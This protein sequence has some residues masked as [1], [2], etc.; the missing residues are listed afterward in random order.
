MCGWRSRTSDSFREHD[1]DATVPQ[2]S[3]VTRVGSAACP[4]GT[5]STERQRDA[6]RA[7]RQ[8]DHALRRATSRRPVPRPGASSRRVESHGK[9]LEIVWDDGLILHTHMR[10]TG[11][12]HLYRSGEPWRRPVRQLRVA[13]RGRRLGRGVLQRAGRRDLPRSSTGAPPGR[14]FARARPVQDGRRPRRCIDRLYHYPD[15]VDAVG[16]VLLDQHV[17]CGVGNV[18]RCEVLWATELSPWAHVGDLTHHDA[19]VLVNTAATMLRR[20]RARS[21]DHEHD[22]RGGLAVYGR[23]GQGCARCHE[24]IA[25]RRVGEHARLLYWCEGCQV[26]LDPRLVDDSPRDGSSPGCG[27]VPFRPSLAA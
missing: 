4:K 14:R 5:R 9:H 24:T 27:Q 16:E 10:M 22:V 18:Y 20:A 17:V 19:V 3:G 26:R 2:R 25:V 1:R 8:A 6:H 7:R 12:W 13:D 11:S 23:N 21:A 15:R